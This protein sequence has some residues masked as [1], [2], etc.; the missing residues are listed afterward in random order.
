MD[1]EAGSSSYQNSG[2]NQPNSQLP[3]DTKIKEL[4]NDV[5]EITNVMKSNINKVLER[6]DR[7]DTLNERSELLN[8][9]ASEFRINS[10][11]VRKK[12]WWD[13][14]RM[15]MIMGTVFLLVIALIIYF[16]MK[17]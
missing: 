17:G 15:K 14:F 12:F 13:N 6:G 16:S 5:N 11:N 7:V 3:G 4:Q 2:S 9:R 1:V 8:S 10:R